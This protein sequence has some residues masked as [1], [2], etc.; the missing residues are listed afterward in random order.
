MKSTNYTK[1]II[2]DY[3]VLD[4]ETTGLSAYYDEVIEIGILRIRDNKIVGRY[5]QLI[6]PKYEIDPFITSL[7]GITNEMVANMPSILDV[8]EEVLAFIGDDIIIGHNTSFDI[9]FLNE[10]FKE[11][12]DN[13][14]MD[15]IQFARKLYPELKHYRLSDLT[16]YLGLYNNEHRAIAD[17]IATKE[18]YDDIKSTMGKK[19]LKI[20]NLW[21]N[22]KYNGGKSIDIKSIAPTT[23]DIDEDNFFYGRHV[24]F[25]GKLEK[26]IRRDAM[27]IVVNL[28]GVLDKNVTKQTNYLILGN[29]DYNAILK[30]EKSSKQKKAERLKLKG[31]DIEVIDEFTFYDL[32]NN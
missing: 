12:L 9:R 17:C 29:N 25:T 16:K 20:E 19:G 27:Q 26:M 22:S 6:Q 14:Y 32:L 7:T 31:Q 28:G 2:S 21:V 4:T 11:L 5:S 23:V 8:K 10:G 18:L 3:C 15:T 24:V 30:G 13:R 1:Q